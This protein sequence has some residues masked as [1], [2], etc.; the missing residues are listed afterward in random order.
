[1]RREEMGVLAAMTDIPGVG[2][3]RAYELFKHVDDTESLYDPPVGL[4]EAFYYVDDSVLAELR[5]L[6]ER[7]SEYVDRFESYE[8]EGIDV[9]AV[10]D[11]RYPTEIR[12][13]PAP[14]LLYAKG[15]L[16][17]LGDL[18]V[19]VSG[20]RETNEVG[21]EWVRSICSELARNGDIIIS[22]GA[23]GADTA[24]H[25]G[26]LDAGGSTIAVLGTGVNVAYPPENRSLLER[27]ARR[28]GLLVSMRPPEAEPKRHAF[29]DRNEVTAALSLGMILV[30]TDGA[31]GTMAQYRLAVE[32]DQPVFVPPESQ[33]ISPGDGLDALREAD[34]TRTVS[35]ARDVNRLLP[36]TE[37][38]QSH[39]G[40]WT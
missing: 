27:I 35:G 40:D 9:I 34:S 20:S 22:G 28:D 32:R 24:A 37:L 19:G 2:D 3:A 14:A 10:E 13:G 4:E 6:R 23:R 15:N 26:A 33:Q 29:L 12:N 17:L 8:S 36:S 1:M 39:L 25:R 7:A 16:E 11:D 5:G 21:K 38:G 18:G 31:G 30:A